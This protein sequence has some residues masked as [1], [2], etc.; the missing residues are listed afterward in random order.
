MISDELR[1]GAVVE[2]AKDNKRL[3]GRG[4][5][6]YRKITVEKNV[7]GT[8]EGSARVKIGDT[9]VLVGVKIDPVEPYED[10]HNEGTLT[11]DAEF[12]A[13][14]HETF[15]PGRPSED[16]I[17]LARI[18]DRGIRS[19]EAI[20]LKALFVEEGKAW[21]VSVDVYVLDHDGNMIDA[22]ALAAVTALQGMKLPKLVDGKVVREN[23]KPLLLK[24]VPTYCTYVKVNDKILLDPTYTE[25]V[26]ADTRITMSVGDG[27]L[28]AIQK[29]G[30]GAFT[31][32]EVM[33]MLEKTFETRKTLLT[34]ITK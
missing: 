11:V 10:R 23:A 34:Y 5:N 7:I 8:A 29:S 20:D 18:V 4:L 32:A 9:Q 15:E 6:D 30:S 25:E 17:E 33:D 13:L 27:M 12:L 28:F 3:D 31:R 26:A 14:A 21:G 1:K 19:S 22:A 2:F 16:S 24:E